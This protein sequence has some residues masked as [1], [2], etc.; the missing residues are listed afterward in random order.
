MIRPSSRAFRKALFAARPTLALSAIAS[1][2]GSQKP[3][4]GYSS[5]MIRGVFVQRAATR[6]ADIAT[7]AAIWRQR[8]RLASRSRAATSPLLLSL[9]PFLS[10]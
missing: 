8:F 6:E 2:D 9:S 10:P 4:T 7:E 3:R 1:L 5:A